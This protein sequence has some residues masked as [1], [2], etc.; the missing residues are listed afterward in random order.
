MGDRLGTLGAVGFNTL[1]AKFP[2]LVGGQSGS[3]RLS[4]NRSVMPLDVLGR[5][6]AFETN[7]QKD[8]SARSLSRNCFLKGSLK[9]SLNSQLVSLI[10]GNL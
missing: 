2:I 5:T 8:K 3:T 4:N 7:V 1:L 6:R 10:H 9:N